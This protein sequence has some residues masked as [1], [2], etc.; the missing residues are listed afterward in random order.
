MNY[1][2]AIEKFGSIEV[3]DLCGD[4]NRQKVKTT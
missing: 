1:F 4:L 3:L 2:L